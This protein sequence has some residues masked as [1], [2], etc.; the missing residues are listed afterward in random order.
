[1]IVTIGY[2]A[3]MQRLL[4]PALPVPPAEGT[5]GNLERPFI[6]ADAALVGLGLSAQGIDCVG[7]YNH[8]GR[9]VLAL[10]AREL[11]AQS[12]RSVLWGAHSGEIFELQIIAE[13]GQI[14]WFADGHNGL[15]SLR[16]VDW[17][18]LPEKAS[19]I[20]LDLYPWIEECMYEILPAKLKGMMF[21]NC[22]DSET[23][24]LTSIVQRWRD[25]F[26][27][28][29]FIQ[30][31][32][33]GDFLSECD[34][35][36]FAQRLVRQGAEGAIVTRAELGIVVAV[37]GQCIARPALP[38]P[39]FRDATGAGAAISTAICAF[40]HRQRVAV[41]AE[42]LAHLALTAGASQ[43]GLSGP[44]DAVSK[45]KWEKLLAAHQVLPV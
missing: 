5:M 24:R 19:V 35:A 38:V 17:S 20:Y 44:L 45:D 28:P 4:V 6:T 13:N 31:S 26:S 2:L 18:S 42:N 7:V 22:G 30:V 16:Q 10:M 14:Q 39:D 3:A 21:L 27:N 1:M 29:I 34:A 36:K 41:S 23:E 43:C 15:R 8:P 40:L 33:K 37:G 32:S 12:V 9:S 11:V 25:R